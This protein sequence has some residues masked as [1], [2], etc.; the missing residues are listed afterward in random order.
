[1]EKGPGA[2]LG[3]AFAPVD[4]EERLESL[5]QVSGLQMGLP[6]SGMDWQRPDWTWE[7]GSCGLGRQATWKAASCLQDLFVP[8]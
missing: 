4:G 5:S 2:G 6:V 8:R 1:M 7:Q 3:S